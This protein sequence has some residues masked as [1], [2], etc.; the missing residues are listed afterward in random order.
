M[1]DEEIN[2]IIDEWSAEWKISVSIEE[3]L[4]IEVGPLEDIP[5]EQDKA[6]D[7]KEESSMT[8]IY[9]NMERQLE[10]GRTKIP[11]EQGEERNTPMS[12]KQK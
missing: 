6:K 5:V 8:P 1:N 10:G 7:S 11:F 12:V 4:D 9:S 3:L 2:A